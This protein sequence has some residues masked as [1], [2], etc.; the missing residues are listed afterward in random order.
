[1]RVPPKYA[2]LAQRVEELAVLV[3]PPKQRKRLR[4]IVVEGGDED[5][6]KARALEEHLTACPQDPR[7]VEDY[8]WI[9]RRIIT[10]VPRSGGSY[11]E[12]GLADIERSRS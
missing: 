5:A 7:G 2:K 3:C 1:M 11:A 9:V 8:D 10:G 12:R 4:V 6:V